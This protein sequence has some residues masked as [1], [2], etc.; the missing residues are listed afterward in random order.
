MIHRIIYFVKN[1]TYDYPFAFAFVFLLFLQLHY[2]THNTLFLIICFAIFVVS[3]IGTRR[4][5]LAMFVCFLIFILTPQQRQCNCPSKI[6]GEVKS[7]TFSN[8]LGLM[9]KS[10]HGGVYVFASKA[11]D[12]LLVGDRVVLKGKFKPIETVKNDSFRRY[13]FS[14]GICCIGYAYYIKK[15]GTTPVIGFFARLRKKIEDE[16]YYF[17]PEKV[18]YFLD[19]SILGDK[20]FSKTIK[21]P[22][23][24]TQTAHLLVVSG[25]HMSFV[26]GLFYMLFFQIV[27]RISFFYRRFNIKKIASLFAV[28]PLFFY[29][30]LI[31]GNIP[32][33]RSFLMSMLVVMSMIFGFRKS[34]YNA[35]FF[36]A[37]LIELF[38]HRAIYNPSFIMSFFMTFVALFLYGFCQ[39]IRVYKI[40]RSLIFVILM[41][42]FAMPLSGYFFGHANLFSALDNIVA[43][44]L[45]GFVVVPL[46][47]VG[48]LV[49]PLF[50]QV[51]LLFFKFL[52]SVVLLYLHLIQKLAAFYYTIPLSFSLPNMVV[53]YLFG[54]GVIG[55]AKLLLHLNNQRQTQP[56]TTS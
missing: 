26:F 20:S 46:S 30:L 29:F 48:I 11:F 47:F 25:L 10:N 34:S 22:F 9:V 31:G 2:E 39:S 43:V 4:V 40:I 14:S 33:I 45:F 54:F 19:S 17:L 24:K 7:K 8:R 16:F 41:S 12:N 44:S 56:Q 52:D 27:S 18:D 37:V 3:M 50:Y 55:L 51:K 36:I 53:I 35:L 6:T 21:E 42:L 32:A 49:V 1:L 23:I 13:L 15:I 5:F 28:V 38:Y